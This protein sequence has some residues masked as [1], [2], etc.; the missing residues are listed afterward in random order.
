MSKHFDQLAD[1]WDNDPAKV[2]RAKLTAEYC[3]KAPVKAKKHLLDFG[4]GT[5]LLSVFLRNDFH[6]I[7]IA[8]SSSEMLRVAQE[9]IT[10]ASIENIDT[11]KIE[12]GISEI[13]GSYSAVVTLMTLHHIEDVDGF[14]RHASR[15][16]E[17]DGALII[18]DLCR[19]DGSF[20]DHIQEYSGH[21]GFDTDKLAERLQTLGFNVVESM[22][23]FAIRKT[24]QHGEEKNY[25]LF[26]M[27]AEK[28]G[29]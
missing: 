16:L 19:E 26:F 1:T 29:D 20:H 7:T 2:E 28:M 3:R 23:Y 5:G 24:D 25:P 18:A 12:K 15:L 13:E 9:K 21:H 11:L 22:E 27:V 14:L 10:S 6:R 8:D 4:G 17:K